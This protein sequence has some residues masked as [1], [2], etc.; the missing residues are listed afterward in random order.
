[1][2]PFH[3][4]GRAYLAEEKELKNG[5]FL[6][7]TM[8]PEGLAPDSQLGTADIQRLLDHLEKRGITVLFPESNI[9]QDSLLKLKEAG[10]Q[11]REAIRIVNQPLYAD[12]MGK[13]GSEAD[14]YQKMMWYNAE[15]IATELMR[16][17]NE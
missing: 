1:M 9:S 12:A 13:E 17:F 6:E 7:R 4:F 10:E 15:L 11:R 3:Y 14:T 8:A 16:A 2:M 5:T